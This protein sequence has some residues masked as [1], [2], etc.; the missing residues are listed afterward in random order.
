LLEA[1]GCSI[2]DGGHEFPTPCLTALGLIAPETTPPAAPPSETLGVRDGT[3]GAT[4]VAPL[5]R[6]TAGRVGRATV[7]RCDA[8]NRRATLEVRG[9]TF[10]RVAALVAFPTAERIEATG[11]SFDGATVVAAAGVASIA[12]KGAA[13]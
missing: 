11:P 2:L 5:G 9:A 1:L 13:A 3:L 8:W 4:P 6:R 12:A 10:L 7:L